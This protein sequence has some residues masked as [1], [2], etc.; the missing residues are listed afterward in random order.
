MPLESRHGVCHGNLTL[1]SPKLEDN[2]KGNLSVGDLI[3]Y[4]FLS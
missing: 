1:V 3:I 4:V 2:T